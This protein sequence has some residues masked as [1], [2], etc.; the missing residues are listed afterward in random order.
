[1]F[2]K[3]AQ[4]CARFNELNKIDDGFR[5]C[6]KLEPIL[7][8]EVQLDLPLGCFRMSQNKM[9]VIRYNKDDFPKSTTEI[10]T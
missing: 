2:A 4:I 1:M 10:I 3:F 9:E 8:G 7:F 6:L 5:G